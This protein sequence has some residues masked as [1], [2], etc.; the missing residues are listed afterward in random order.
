M[1]M[2]IA[3]LYALKD[4][5]LSLTVPPI[6]SIFYIT[7]RNGEWCSVY[8]D[9]SGTVK[10]N[11]IDDVSKYAW[12]NMTYSGEYV[13]LDKADYV[14]EWDDWWK[15]DVYTGDIQFDDSEIPQ[16]D[17]EYISEIL[18]YNRVLTNDEIE[19]LH[20]GEF[21]LDGCV[22]FIPCQ[23][24]IGDT[25]KDVINNIELVHGGTWIYGRDYIDKGTKV[26]IRL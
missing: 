13:N 25:V 14:N 6:W 9:F 21:I 15:F 5:A 1:Q 22:N 18:I 24:G 3:N 20:N 19:R 23:E 16:F 10:V 4:H 8:Q 12:A 2:K 26:F 17:I 7:K 11:N